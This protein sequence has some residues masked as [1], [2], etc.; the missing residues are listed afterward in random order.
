MRKNL[1]AGLVLIL[2][3]LIFI[4]FYFAGSDRI[5]GWLNELQDDK[6]SWKEDVLLRDGSLIVVNRTARLSENFM[7]G[8]GGGV[9]NKGMTLRW[10]STETKEMLN[11]WEDS[12][13]PLIIDRD[14]KTREWIV[15]ATF[16]HCNEW[17]KL[18]RP[19]LPYVAYRYSNGVWVREALPSYFVGRKVNLYVAVRK[20]R[21]EHI[22]LKWKDRAVPVNADEQFK[23]IVGEWKTTC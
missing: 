21:S 2:F 22:G 10:E 1:S 15:V 16:F 23:L 4:A 7:A 19:E 12:Y 6:Y 14:L 9:I 13:V 3:G 20:P 18:G 11:S 8:G 17:Y 5:F